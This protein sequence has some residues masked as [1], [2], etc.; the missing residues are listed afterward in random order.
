[1][2]H[3]I[4]LLRKKPDRSENMPKV[5]EDSFKPSHTQSTR[6][7]FLN[8]EEPSYLE[9][10]STGIKNAITPEA[11]LQS[12]GF[13]HSPESIYLKYQKSNIM[14]LLRMKFNLKPMPSRNNIELVGKSISNSSKVKQRLSEKSPLS[15][16]THVAYKNSTLTGRNNN[17]LVSIRDKYKVAQSLKDTSY[18]YL[19]VRKSSIRSITN[20]NLK[21]NHDKIR[22]T[23]TK[24]SPI[25]EIESNSVSISG[26]D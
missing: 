11:C 18:K 15:S 12:K 5:S 25:P 24:P 8:P 4:V 23:Q 7:N 20:K 2:N 22:F 14:Q 1:M 19:P 16:A 9:Y 17:Y 26:W 13:S 3:K 21:S 6:R 10:N